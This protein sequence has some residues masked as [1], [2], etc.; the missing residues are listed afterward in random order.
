M[1]GLGISPFYT[2]RKG[3]DANALA[4]I[5]A[6]GITNTGQQQAI[7]NFVV[8]LKAINLIQTGFV[9]FSTPANSII[10]ALYPFVGGTAASHKW[11]L[12]NPVDSDAAFR[13]VFG[14]T[15]T[16]SSMG[17]K[18]DGSTGYA[19]TFLVPATDL[20][21]ND[22]SMFYYP[23]SNVVTTA[24]FNQGSRTGSTQVFV[25]RTYNASLK[26]D[27]FQYNGSAG[28]GFLETT[29]TWV[30]N[31]KT[32]TIKQSVNKLF[33]NQ[34]YLTKHQMI[35][36]GVL[37]T[38]NATSGGTLPTH[39]CYLLG[40]NNVG[41]L[42]SAT[43]ITCGLA[44]FGKGMTAAAATAFSTACDTFQRNMNRFRNTTSVQCVGDSITWGLSVPNVSPYP[45][46]LEAL[47]SSPSNLIA[48]NFGVSGKQ[49]VNM[50]TDYAANEGTYYFN[51]FDNNAL[52]LMAGVNDLGQDLN[53]TE[54][55]LKARYVS[56]FTL[57]NA[58]GYNSF[59]CELLPQSNPAYAA[60]TDYETIRQSVNAW[61]T[62]YLLA[63]GYVKAVVP[64][65][66]DSRIG[67]N[68]SQL[69][70]TY[71]LQ[72]TKIHPTDTGSGVIAELV[73]QTLANYYSV[74]I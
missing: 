22:S 59:V 18:G 17:I 44:G 52:V 45:T 21:T 33:I 46:Q 57:A 8:N 4:F 9:D 40:Y 68:G 51:K 61:M 58:T 39:K 64:T 5:T 63:N 34:R 10:K 27:A 29:S 28:Q 11:N 66:S 16:H 19:D 71:Y 65:G 14:G 35:V 56:Y 20:A 25:N 47:Y 48:N 49:L 54:A 24:Q 38:E 7:N 43:D 15:V 6:A 74:N 2:T 60:R 42:A 37:D 30:K 50:I 26:A 36:N 23:V 3:Y 70:S 53:C 32:N 12:I 62:T 31:N 13:L 69:N 72:D 55:D 1:I 67:I 73:K 41:A